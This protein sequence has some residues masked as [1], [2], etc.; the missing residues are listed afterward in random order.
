MPAL[1]GLRGLAAVVVLISHLHMFNWDIYNLGPAGVMLFFVLSGFLMAHLHLRQS[2]NAVSVRRFCAART[3]RIVPLYYAVV[4]LGYLSTYH[5]GLDAFS[6]Y[7]MDTLELARHLLFTGK[8][9][10]FWSVGPEFQ[11]Y[12]FFVLM[13]GITALPVRWR[14]AALAALAVFA[15]ACYAASPRLPG[16]LFV[17]KLQIFLF[18]VAVAI[19]RW[20]LAEHRPLTGFA[21]GALQLVGVIALVLLALPGEFMLLPLFPAAAVADYGRWYYADLPRALFAAIAVLGFSYS[22]AAS[23][24]LLGNALMREL[25]RAS[26]SIYLLHEPV[27]GVMRVMGLFEQASAWVSIPLCIVVSVL[28]SSAVNRLFET[29]VRIWLTRRLSPP[30]HEVGASAAAA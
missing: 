12:G 1:D 29:P 30:R 17:S 4:V 7:H 23:T 24:A 20:W 2:F 14:K 16:I 19:V 21:K 13:W 6:V 27:I 3:A 15:V 28:V 22:T 25:G 11:F 8:V 26:F 10:V 18:G 5:L 9:S